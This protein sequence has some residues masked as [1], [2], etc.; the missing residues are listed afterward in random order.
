MPKAVI[1]F[2]RYV[3]AANKAVGKFSMY[4]VIGMGGVLLF[5]SIA[6][7]IF[8]QP[9]IWVVEVAQFLMAAYYLLGG[10]Y[11]MILKGHV[12]M[13]LLYGRWSVKRQALADLITGPFLMFYLIF[14]LVGAI[15]AIEY[16]VSYGQKK[17]YPMGTALGPHQ[18]YH[19]N[20][21]LADAVADDG[22]IFQGPGQV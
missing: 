8:N 13:D 9:H 22:Q 16:A 4:L 12:R 1:V 5:E 15:S 10:G 3:E 6:R 18:N 17:L 19:G 20:R 2:V 11:S 21:D 7:T 14:L